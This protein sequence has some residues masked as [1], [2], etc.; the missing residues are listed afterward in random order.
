MFHV[1]VKV[2]S[3]GR[4]RYFLCFGLGIFMWQGLVLKG[5]SQLLVSSFHLHLNPRCRSRSSCLTAPPL[6]TVTASPPAMTP[7]ALE[8]VGSHIMVP[9]SPSQQSLFQSLFMFNQETY[10]THNCQT[11]F[12]LSKF[13]FCLSGVDCSTGECN[14]WLSQMFVSPHLLEKKE[15]KKKH[16]N[17]HNRVYVLDTVLYLLSSWGGKV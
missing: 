2:F 14:G 10:T 7:S 8:R 9:S 12:E 4:I 6:R 11:Q 1:T 16:K 5:I 17:V 15:K 13:Q 3:M